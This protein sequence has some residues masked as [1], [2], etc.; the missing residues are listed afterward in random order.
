MRDLARH[1]STARFIAT[2]LARHFSADEPSSRLISR[3]E[4]VYKRSDG[5][6]LRVTAALAEAPEVWKE[7]LTKVRNPTEY[8]ISLLRATG[9]EP[10][11]ESINSALRDLG[12]SAFSAPSPKGWPDVAAAWIAPESLMR[13]IELA[14][15]AARNMKSG[16]NPL[17]L[18]QDTI[19]PVA[20][21]DTL[22]WIEAAPDPQTGF[23]LALA[24]AE[25]QRR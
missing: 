21:A 20:R 9:L 22:K 16:M 1:P 14:G 4:G 5:D 6:L 25:A 2:K 15:E 7:P 18:A 24:A 17:Q 8:I 13:R 3:L 23:T 12:Q 19:G 11:M 10:N